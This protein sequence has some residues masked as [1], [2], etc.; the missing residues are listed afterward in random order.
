MKRRKKVV[1]E[2]L[3]SNKSRRSFIKRGVAGLAGAAFMPSILSSNPAKGTSSPGKLIYRKL[4]KTGIKLPVVSMGVMNADNP[5]LVR[6]ALE[7]GIVHLDTA[8]YYQFGRNEEMIGQV[9]KGRARDSFV[10]GTKV[11]EPRDMRTGLFPADAKWDTFIEKFH[12]S[13]KR[14]GLDYVDILYLHNVSRKESVTFEPYLAA[15]KKMKKEGKA[16]FI[17]VS[18][19]RN[20]AEVIRAAAASNEYDVVLTA[21]N[22]KMENLADVKKAIDEA[23]KKGLGIVA[24]KTQAGV[25]WDG[26]ERQFPINMKAALKWALQ[27]ENIHT[28]IP[29]MTTFD[30][31]ELDVSVMKDI[32]LTPQEKADLVPPNGISRAGFYCD[33]CGKC[34]E[35]CPA[36]LAIPTIMRSYMYTYAYRNLGHARATLD[37][38]PMAAL[39]CQDCSVCRVNCTRGFN[40]KERTLDVARLRDVPAD[41]LA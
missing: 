41:L 9:V 14:L 15:L 20:E 3:Q 30:Q 40:I 11:F 38:A 28:A 35:Q 33:Q 34:L 13:L 29:G 25:Y 12:T 22:F 37:L 32:T 16:R 1:K 18:T 39:P 31:L 2:R 26:K 8:W 21:Y 7:A 4:G 17:G 23:A 24:M 36:G 10:I 6:A 27:N 19:H 5:Q